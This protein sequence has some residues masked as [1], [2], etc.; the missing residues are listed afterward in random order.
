MKSFWQ[1]A[2]GRDQWSLP[3]AAGTLPGQMSPGGAIVSFLLTL[4]GLWSSMGVGLPSVSLQRFT[5]TEPV[6]NKRRKQEHRAP[7]HPAVLPARR[8]LPVGGAPRRPE[9]MLS[10]ERL[11]TTTGHAHPAQSS[12]YVDHVLYSKDERG[13]I[14]KTGEAQGLPGDCRKSP[15]WRDL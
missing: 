15:G 10:W 3:G 4:I 6:V 9:R 7:A 14:E 12:F 5:A 2:R 13:C 11:P 1:Q 8:L